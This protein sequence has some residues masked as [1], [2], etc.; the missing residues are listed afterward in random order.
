MANQQFGPKAAKV[1][2]DDQQEGVEAATKPEGDAG[3]ELAAWIL[4]RTGQWRD[5]RRQNYDDR[6]A[7]YERLWR[8]IYSP[9]EKQRK[10]EQATLIGPALAEAVENCV[11]EVEE[12]LF[13]RGD[14]FDIRPERD[15]SDEAKK[16]LA[17]NKANLKE[18]LDRI[19]YIPNASEALMNG[20]VY[21]TGIGEIVVKSFML[22]DIVVATQNAMLAMGPAPMPAP[23][24]GMYGEPVAAPGPM[25]A[26][27]GGMGAEMGGM[28][29]PAPMAAPQPAF[30][31][32]MAAPA[33][34]MQVVEKEVKYACM[35][36]VNPRNF[37]IDPNARTIDDALGCAIEEYV[38]T[39]VIRK[40]QEN[41]E[42]RKV[43]FGTDAGDQDILVDKEQEN[44]YT[45]DKAH[46]LRYYGLVPKKLL[47][48]V[49]P[50]E[51]AEQEEQIVDLFP[52]EEATEASQVAMLSDPKEESGEPTDST[53]VEAI[54]VLVNRKSVLKGVP[55]PYIMQD[56][57]VVAFPWDII[58]GRFWGRG[59]CEKGASA[60]KMSDAEIRYRIDS[61]RYAAAPMIGI[62]ATRLPRGFKFEVYPG[63][64]IL[65]TGDPKTVLT[66]FKFGEL[67]Q[68]TWQQG[69]YL[70]QIIQRATGSLDVI[71]LA[72]KGGDTRPG[73]MS[74]MLSGIVK[75]HK[76][77]L[78]NF[79]N[80][81]IA[82]SMKKLLWRNMQFYP[83]RYKAANFSFVPS[84]TMGIMQRE[85]EMQSMVQLLNTTPPESPVYKAIVAGVI[86]NTGLA[87]REKFVGLLNE[88]AA[89]QMQP[90]PVDPMAEQMKQM[91]AQLELAK[92]AAEVAKLN[93]QA[94]ESNAQAEE[95]KA[96]ARQ[97]MLQPQIDAMQ[98]A[99]KGIYATPE[100]QQSA[101][102]DRRM[103]MADLM[104]REED[105]ASN[106]RIARMQ[107][108]ASAHG[109]AVKAQADVTKEAI[110]ARGSV[111]TARTEASTPQV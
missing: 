18:D 65:T 4:A 106:E 91:A 54:V 99:T 56:R 77:T 67:D 7:E 97:L 51:A 82:P 9:N 73:A 71:S 15:D 93:A 92:M 19:D 27:M 108:G 68:N 80:K 28:P 23:E 40:G 55:S 78:M 72:T 33:P 42:Y 63:K 85:Y 110:K 107:A 79:I 89:A 36:S 37:L 46:V 41:G 6:W 20:A 74:M 76:R 60:Q 13:G 111:A 25:G 105:I 16:I 58:P 101:E 32:P 95:N 44:E 70:D 86:T 43:E 26:E 75:R 57:P 88:Q 49:A 94:A 66:P 30:Q 83:E 59:V 47:D 2:A 45:Q 109:A 62:D 64:S 102:F 22:R 103:A 1:L 38:G 84:A 5:H 31:P 87:D 34:D 12:A 81:F 10:R 39:H 52:G 11:A 104:L 53:M 17:D 3:D 24:M 14:F 98:A 8:G 50:D 21:G 48:K 29:A 96:K 100:D 35:H 69:Q 90:P 61:L